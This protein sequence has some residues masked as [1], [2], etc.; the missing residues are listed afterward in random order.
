M[1]KIKAITWSFLRT[2]FQLISYLYFGLSPFLLAAIYYLFNSVEGLKFLLRID[3]GVCN[4][5]HGV[6]RTISGLTDERATKYKR[7]YFQEIAINVLAYPFDK[8]WHHCKRVNDV[9]QLRFKRYKY[10]VK[11][12]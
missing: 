5:A 3:I 8:K 10:Y 7:Y 9:E 4:I 11:I 2:I 12:K 1:N 6:N